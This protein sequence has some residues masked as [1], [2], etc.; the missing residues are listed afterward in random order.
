MHYSQ[1]P[2]TTFFNEKNFKTGSHSTIDTFKNYFVIVFSVFN[3]K[4]Y[5][6][7]PIIYFKHI[8][9]YERIGSSLAGL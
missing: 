2:Q 3:N 5:P 1:D 7:R 8:L 9:K 4:R 6:N